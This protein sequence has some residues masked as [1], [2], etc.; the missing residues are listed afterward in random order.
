ML[1]QKM[2]KSYRNGTCPN[3]PPDLTLANVLEGFE[4]TRQ[5]TISTKF[6]MTQNNIDTICLSVTIPGLGVCG[7]L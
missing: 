7:N 4:S 6:K 2:M 1:F 5:K 3:S